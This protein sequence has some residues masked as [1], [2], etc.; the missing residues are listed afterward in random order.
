MVC[1]RL[2]LIDPRLNLSCWGLCIQ[3][4]LSIAGEGIKSRDPE[5]NDHSGDLPIANMASRPWIHGSNL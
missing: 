5:F 3:D 4:R 1:V 2:R